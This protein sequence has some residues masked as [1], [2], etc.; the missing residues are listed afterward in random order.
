MAEGE[1]TQA[2]EEDRAGFTPRR[3]LSRPN[4]K[5]D[6]RRDRVSNIIDTLRT[7]EDVGALRQAGRKREETDKL[8]RVSSVAEVGF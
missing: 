5:L 1:R 7:I 2:R 8:F 6:L 3:R 4:G